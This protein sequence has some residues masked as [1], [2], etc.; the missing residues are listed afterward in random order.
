[1]KWTGYADKDNTWEP[2]E[3]LAGCEDMIAEFKE[4]QRTRIAQH[5]A[6]AQA[7]HAEKAAA[8]AQTVAEAA[9]T[10]AAAARVEAADEDQR[11]SPRNEAE[12]LA[13]VLRPWWRAAPLLPASMT[14]VPVDRRKFGLPLTRRGRRRAHPVWQGVLAASCGSSEPCRERRVR[15]VHLDWGDI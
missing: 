3:H 11:R 6:A 7:K 12:R 5:K 1:M 10:S 9:A 13:A 2:I 4:R 8:A 14:R 15:G